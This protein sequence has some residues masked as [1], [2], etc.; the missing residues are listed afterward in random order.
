MIALTD[1][2]T[3]TKA[4]AIVAVAALPAN[5]ADVTTSLA[6]KAA[7]E[8]VMVVARNA[9]AS[10]FTKAD[11]LSAGMGADQRTYDGLGTATDTLAAVVAVTAATTGV[12]QTEMNLFV[13][14]VN[15]A[16]DACAEYVNVLA[17][18][19]A[20]EPITRVVI[21][22]SFPFDNPV[23]PQQGQST[24][25][26]GTKFLTERQ[27]PTP[28]AAIPVVG[29]T[30]ADPGQQKADI[31]TMFTT[32]KNNIATLAAKINDIRTALAGPLVRIV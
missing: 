26:A 10:L 25:Q 24:M 6:Q 14:E 8:A 18:I 2:S 9:I 21:I 20:V 32:V 5:T 1:S 30:A 4:A 12:L 16:L 17:A 28:G 29:G 15:E 31:D 19:M 7:A 11:A 22:A 23:N 27:D 13:T 3:G